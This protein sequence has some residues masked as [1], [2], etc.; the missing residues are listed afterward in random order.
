MKKLTY[1]TGEKKEKFNY[2]AEELD[3]INIISEFPITV[4]VSDGKDKTKCLSLNRRSIAELKEFLLAVE[5]LL[6]ESDV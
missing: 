4:Q 3:K 6:P 1:R 2:Y 5:L